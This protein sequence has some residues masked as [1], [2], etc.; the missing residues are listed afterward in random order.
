MMDWN[1]LPPIPLAYA[2]EAVFNYVFMWCGMSI[3]AGAVAK[4][5]IPG[6][7]L[8]GTLWTF[9]TGFLSMSAGAFLLKLFYRHALDVEEFNPFHPFVLL[10]AIVIGAAGVFICRCVSSIFSKRF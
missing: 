6:N 8:R 4:L 5:L 9:L 7:T 2:L 10:L 1:F 3:I